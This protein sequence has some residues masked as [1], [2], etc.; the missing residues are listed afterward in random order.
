MTIQKVLKDG[1]KYSITKK[2]SLMNSDLSKTTVT[3]FIWRFA[4]RCGAQGVT[5]IVSIILARII[6]PE[7]YG[8]I[9]IV[10]IFTTILQIF[11]DSGL[12]TALIQKKNADQ[13]DFSTV[14]WTNFF[15]CIFL[16]IIMFFLSPVI[17]DFFSDK[18]LKNIIRVLSLIIIV[19]GI[20]NVQIAYVSRKLIFKKFF[21]STLIGTLLAAVMGI[22]MAYMGFGVWALVFQ[23]I[24]NNV[25]DTCILWITV[26][27]RPTFEFS[28][29]RLKNLFSYGWKLLLS[30]LI[31]AIYND[32]W[33][34]IIGKVYTKS[35]LAFYNRGKQF[36]QFVVLNINNSIDSVLLPVMSKEQESTYNVKK[37]ASLSIKISTFC[38]APIMLGLFAIAPN[39]VKLILTDKWLG[40]VPYLR[41]FC[42]T[43][44]FYPIHTANLNAIK[45]VGR[46]DLFLK[47][48]IIKFIVGIGLLF[49]TLKHGVMI[50]S[51][52]LLISSLISQIINSWPN[53]KLLSYSYL[54]QVKDIFSNLIIAVIMCLTIMLIGTIEIHY[55]ILLFIQVVIGMAEYV[56]LAYI[57][58]NESFF[59][60]ITL[61]EK[62]I[63]KKENRD[64]R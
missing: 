20:K 8:T 36:P 31:D 55:L 29:K 12:G 7:V 52:S 41:I 57:T 25:I 32:I 47:L 1:K 43:Y 26:E 30:S 40:C 34:F 5:F 33:Q 11:V 54:E 48:E 56:G 59:Y 58:K 64:G 16:Y 4:E 35:D 22:V 45:A 51:Y 50:M 53:K 49:A 39:F 38:M 15:V 62:F 3:N 10:T 19:S 2:V 61:I 6:D 63:F 37:M 18:Y 28:F 27:W 60:I 9:A 14:F 21:F 24:L 13:K 42:V 46:S 44:M 23:Q 17:A